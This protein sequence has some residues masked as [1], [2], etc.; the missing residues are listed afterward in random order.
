MTSVV[1]FC[2]DSV[3]KD[4][5][6]R[7]A[8]RLKKMSDFS[9]TDC[10]SGSSWS[11]PSHASFLTG[12]LP[13]EHGIHT[14]NMDFSTV[15]REDVITGQLSNHHSTY[16]SAN[17]FTTPEFGFNSWFDSG[18]PISAGRH[19]PKGIDAK[20]SN[21]IQNHIRRSLQTDHPVKSFLNGVVLKM[22]HVVGNKPIANLLDDGCKPISKRALHVATD[23]REN[24]FMF[25][26][27]MEAH[28]PHRL[29]RGM[30]QE[31][32][33]LSP[34]WS[35]HMI[36]HWDYNESNKEELDEFSEDLDRFR[37]FYAAAI[38][39]LDRRI[40]VLIEQ[41]EDAL[42]DDV[43]AIIMADHGE[44]L[45][46][47]HDRYLME[48]TGALTEGLLHVPFEVVNSP[49]D[50]DGEGSLFSL[51][52]LPDLVTAIINGDDYVLGTNP[53]S[54][55]VIGEGLHLDEKKSNYWDRGIR[56]AYDNV[57]KFEWDTFGNQLRIDI[58]VEGPSTE[59]VVEEDVTLD[60]KL[61]E[62]FKTDLQ[63]YNDN[64]NYRED[65][66]SKKVSESTESRLRE[67]GYL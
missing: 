18:Y 6:D 61:Y 22:D 24:L 2:L 28:I 57:S 45:G 37:E 42:Y 8:N 5:F 20:N 56:C 39:Y 4:Y 7:Y 35:S 32:F 41:L 54:A 30:D 49:I 66:Q 65:T 48:H 15:K 67:L 52:E 63:S 1:V 50:I 25:I 44:N 19:F 16:V 10:R 29:F 58:N 60:N 33:D 23:H 55:E 62:R 36:D 3:R 11:V 47:K 51:C 21:G 59:L 27:M 12:S 43:V 26:N 34:E 9:M 31:Q 38:E 46:G 53:V 14:Y 17:Q 13:S 64:H 40:S